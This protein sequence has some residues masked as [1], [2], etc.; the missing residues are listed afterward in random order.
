MKHTSVGYTLKD[1]TGRLSL[2]A[3]VSPDMAEAK[4][5]KCWRMSV[6]NAKKKIAESGYRIVPVTITERAESDAE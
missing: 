5:A 6:E 4:L 1:Q 2:W 3:E